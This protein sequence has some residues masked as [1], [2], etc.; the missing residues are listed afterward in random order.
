MELLEDD[1][2]LTIKASPLGRV[3][4]EA[5]GVV[6]QVRPLRHMQVGSRR[7]PECEAIVQWYAAGGSPRV[8]FNERKRPS[9]KQSADVLLRQVIPDAP[10]YLSVMLQLF[11]RTVHATSPLN[12]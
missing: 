5:V 4:E 1:E 6:F 11:K 7:L 2:A 12:P 8:N 3:I 9:A 10:A